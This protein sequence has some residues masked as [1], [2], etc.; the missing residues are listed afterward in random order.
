MSAG[1][2][3]VRAAKKRAA[4]VAVLSIL[5]AASLPISAQAGCSMPAGSFPGGSLRSPV[6]GAM[7]Q[8]RTQHVIALDANEP[9]FGLWQI[10]ATYPYGVDHVISG[11][12][13]DGLEF[14]QDIA[15]IL[16]GYVCY[17]SY[18]KL[19]KGI[20]GLTH[21]FFNFQDVNSNGEG[22]EAT[23]GQWDGTSGFF[24]YTVTVSKD[25]KSF[26][27]NENLTVVEGPNPYDPSAS[28]LFTTTATLSATKV[29]VD[30]SQ[31]P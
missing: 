22:T 3:I 31:L 2:I 1:Q 26:T 17:G 10:T 29:S 21:P 14:D 6:G 11:W 27:G 13:R 28:V 30:P 16:T 7:P 9:I 8:H 23:E 4:M 18:V 12:T 20:Y 25:G 15:P 5:A 19:G 24:D